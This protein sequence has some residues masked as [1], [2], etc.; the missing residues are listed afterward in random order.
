M[1]RWYLRRLRMFFARVQRYRYAVFVAFVVI[2]YYCCP[3]ADVGIDSSVS[4][5]I[6]TSTMLC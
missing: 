4:G 2:H 5:I 6:P 3:S 1:L